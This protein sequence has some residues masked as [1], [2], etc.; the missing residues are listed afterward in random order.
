[1]MN[2]KERINEVSRSNEEPEC[3]TKHRSLM[4]DTY[5]REPLHDRVLPLWR[6]SDPSC[7]ILNGQD[8]SLK[9]SKVEF[10][11][12]SAY[13]S[14]NVVLTDIRN[15]FKIESLKNTI[16]EKFGLLLKKDINKTN[17]LNEATWSCGYFLYV[18]E[19]VKLEKPIVVKSSAC[20][21]GFRSVRILVILEKGSSLN[22]I[23]ETASSNDVSVFSNIVA[24][25]YLGNN[26]KLNY[27]T[28]QTNGTNTTSH[29]FQR[30]VLYDYAELT[31][32][33]VSVG[34]KISKADIGTALDGRNSKINTYGIVVG[35][36]NQKFDHHTTIEHL[37]PST[38]SEVQF[39]AVLKGR[40]Q[41]AY[42][43]NLKIKEE[44]VKSDAYQE[45]RNLLLSEDARAESIP[46]LEILTNDVTRCSHA[47]TVGQVDKDQMYYLTSRGLSEKESEKI[48][49]EGF[50]EPTISRIP[51]DSLKEEVLLKVQKKLESL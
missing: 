30:A 48:I 14:Q 7:F 17:L 25:I 47:V 22:L 32:L 16:K 2:I 36:T 20:D 27:L 9:S 5:L 21:S 44:A 37:K 35:D 31:N 8:I 12:D 23:E 26:S 15:I 46:E 51:L 28:L 33:V 50:L 49:V 42:T 3:I 29:V 6:Y 34:G 43:G 38:K 41:S 45:N 11:I 10:N 13:L 40:S 24:E 4:W 18:P 39:R 1:M 19:N